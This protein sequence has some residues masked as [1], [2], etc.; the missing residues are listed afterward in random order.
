[1]TDKITEE[2]PPLEVASDSPRLPGKVNAENVILGLMAVGTLVLSGLLL[3]VML[4]QP[5]E[6]TDDLIW[7]TKLRGNSFLE[8][9]LSPAWLVGSPFYRPVAEFFLKVLYTAFGFNPTPYRYVQFAVFLLLVVLSLQV[10]RRLGLRWEAVLLI[11]VFLIGSPFISWSMAWLSELPHIIVLVCFVAAIAVI[12]SEQSVPTKLCLTGLAFAIALLSKEN[13]LALIVFYVY[14]LRTAPFRAGAVFG[15]I[16]AVYFVMRAIVLGPSVGAAG[17]EDSAGWFF[18]YLSG[19]ERRALFSG[20]AIYQLYI[21]NILA[22]LAALGFR[23]TQWGVIF[24]RPNY[25]MILETASTALIVAGAVVLRKRREKLSIVLLIIAAT[26][27]GGTFFSYSYAR[28]RHLALPALA[29][30]F[31][32]VIAVNELGSRSRTRAISLFACVWMAWSVQAI[33]TLRAMQSA[34]VELVERVYQ[35]NLTSPD[36]HVPLDVWTTAREDALARIPRSPH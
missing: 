7:L 23:I 1:M 13:G 3:F 26:A 27:V 33:F 2:L 20:Y 6:R 11:T 8:L 32:L 35:P 10:V 15:G 29:Y 30:A 21:Y 5:F 18:R 25:Q 36:P 19:E 17:V 14:F 9:P 28:D 34:S 22:Q 4:K 12:L 16:T 24:G 31:L